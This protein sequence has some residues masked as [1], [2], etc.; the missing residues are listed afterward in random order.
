M[1]IESSKTTLI[2]SSLFLVRPLNKYFKIIERIELFEWNSEW[3]SK[4]G[5]CTIFAQTIDSHRRVPTKSRKKFSIPTPYHGH[6]NVR[7]ALQRTIVLKIFSKNKER[8]S[9]LVLLTSSPL[10]VS[11]FS[12]HFGP[13]KMIGI[14]QELA[15]MNIYDEYQFNQISFSI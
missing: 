9:S 14:V 7:E 13:E 10:Q 3:V 8:G 4:T 12:V 11:I 6:I 15:E 1:K 5:W 2:Q